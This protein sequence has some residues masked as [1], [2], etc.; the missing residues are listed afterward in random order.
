MRKRQ[1]VLGSVLV[2]W[3]LALV[4][5]AGGISILSA[6]ML[7]VGGVGL[8]REWQSRPRTPSTPRAPDTPRTDPNAGSS[9]APP[10]FQP[11]TA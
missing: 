2:V 3:G 9:V 11:P 8:Y 7:G 6:I 4:V 10:G 5:Y 1:L